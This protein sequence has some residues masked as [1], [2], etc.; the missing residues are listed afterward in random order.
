MARAPDPLIEK[1]KV[2]YLEGVKLVEI[3][4]QLNLPEGTVRRWKCTHKW[5]NERSDKKS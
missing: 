4:S 5:D 1:A 2:M 3:A